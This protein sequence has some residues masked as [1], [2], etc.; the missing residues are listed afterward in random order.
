MR[1]KLSP[2]V[3]AV[4]PSAESVVEVLASRTGDVVVEHGAQSAL[5]LGLSTG[6]P[7]SPVFLTSGRSRVFNLGGLKVSLKHVSSRKLALGASPAG[8]AL[9]A[10]WFMGEGSVGVLEV[11]KVASTLSEDDFQLLVSSMP[12]MPSWLRDVFREYLATV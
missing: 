11:S 9:R 8:S 7:V 1:P 6:V 3:G 10:L 2:W 5:R 4:S 12:L